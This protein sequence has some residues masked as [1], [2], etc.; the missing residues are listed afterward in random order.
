[1]IITW[2]SWIFI[3]KTEHIS[4]GKITNITSELMDEGGHYSDPHNVFFAGIGD[5]KFSL[6]KSNNLARSQ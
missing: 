4:P 1:M 3:P 2:S 5:R 6:G